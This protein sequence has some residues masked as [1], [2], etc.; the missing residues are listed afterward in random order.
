[1]SDLKDLDTLLS[2]LEE[3][4]PE[5]PLPSLEEQKKIAQELKELEARGELSP[6]IMEKH[7]AKICPE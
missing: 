7:F 5:V 2:G 1:M 3:K 6:E 4:K